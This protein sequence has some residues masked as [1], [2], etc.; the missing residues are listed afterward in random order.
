VPLAD[1]V[2]TRTHGI[3]SRSDE[4]KQ[5]ILSYGAKNPSKFSGEKKDNKYKKPYGNDKRQVHFHEKEEK[6]TETEP[7]GIEVSTHHIKASDRP[8]EKKDDN[9]I[10]KLATTKSKPEDRE[11]NLLSIN[12]IMSQPSKTKLTVSSHDMERSPYQYECF[13]I[14]ANYADF[15]DSDD[16][17]T[18]NEG[19][20]TN[21]DAVRE[22]T[23]DTQD[24]T[25]SEEQHEH[26]E[27]PD[28]SGKP[29]WMSDATYLNLLADDDTEDAKPPSH[30]EH[31]DL[32]SVPD[33]LPELLPPRFG[34]M[35][36]SGGLN[37]NAR[38]PHDTYVDSSDEESV[39]ENTVS[40]EPGQ[41]EFPDHSFELDTT[42][43]V[44]ES[45]TT[46]SKPTALSWMSDSAI[47]DLLQDEEAEQ[48]SHTPDV[49]EI[50]VKKATEFM[51]G[52]FSNVPK[53][54]SQLLL[55][56]GTTTKELKASLRKQAPK[57]AAEL[58]ENP[59][60]RELLDLSE[61]NDAM[62]SELSAVEK[63]G[64]FRNVN[65][66]DD[67]DGYTTVGNKKRTNKHKKKKSPKNAP[68]PAPTPKGAMSTFCSMVSPKS[69]AQAAM[70][71][72]SSSQS[73]PKSESDQAAVSSSPPSQSSQ[74]SESDQAKS[75][76]SDDQAP[77]SSQ[78]DTSSETDQPK[79][80]PTNDGD[81]ES[82]Q[83]GQDQDF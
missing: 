4:S 68:K 16:E 83:T 69:Y 76:S 36:I 39:A 63:A 73:S 9:G 59:I 17:D 74:K 50:P 71:S 52:Q 40:H 32:E 43:D 6:D 72:S 26:E 66:E 38:F 8:P 15:I 34:K 37:L 58:K 79:S 20:G 45:N 31:D 33:D 19:P 42:L 80:S 57:K 65:L 78:S 55:R 64:N 56:A 54:T 61:F 30:V 46:V 11:K 3:P 60:K 81:D 10:L 29:A 48:E 35:N 53:P 5:K 12:K 67:Y 7:S 25:T 14:R 2:W 47:A 75:S 28:L 62:I 13:A 23:G 18:D 27:G 51:K 44:R 77:S 21:D 24:Q 22:V 1:H 49:T 41:D 82:R 70:S